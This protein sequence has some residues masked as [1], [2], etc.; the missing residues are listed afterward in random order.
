[1]KR[2][3]QATV[4]LALVA[5]ASVAQAQEPSAERA[6][7]LTAWRQIESVI[8]HPRCINCHTATE[9]PRQ[10]DE[11]RRHDFRV[12]RGHE[13]KG[14][15]GALCISCHGASNN[16][17]SSVPGGPNWHLAPPG[18]AWER[19]PG[20]RMRSAQLCTTFKDQARN[21]GHTPQK[22]VEH[23]ATEP[24]VLWAWEPGEQHSGAARATPPISHAALLAA[25]RSW[26]DAGAPCP[27]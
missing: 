11:R 24:L 18:M 20:Q 12:M 17:V 8:T 7:G 21:G 4:A 19:A 1:M 14:T 6:A 9:Y 23:H 5:A 15:P 13:G 22:M 25:T 16:R 27:R 26:A 2:G 3:V 10:G